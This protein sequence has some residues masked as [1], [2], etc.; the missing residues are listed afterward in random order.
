MTRSHRLTLI[1]GTKT[2]QEFEDAFWVKVDRTSE[3][4][5]WTGAPFRTGMGYG[6][7]SMGRRP[8]AAHRIAWLLTYGDIPEDVNILH[9]CDRPLCCRPDHLFSG[10][11]SD[12]MKDMADKGRGRLQRPFNRATGDQHGSRLHPESRPR[13]ESH[14]RARLTEQQV[15][16]MRQ[17]H[18]EGVR[19]VDLVARYGVPKD[20]VSKV[21]HEITWRHV[22]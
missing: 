17:L 22:R 16:E 10:D 14:P 11:Q 6:Q 4:W 8:V 15:R 21:I 13:G 12:N 9:Q 5:L 3:C 20:V 18:R 7:A 1:L 19:P 2:R